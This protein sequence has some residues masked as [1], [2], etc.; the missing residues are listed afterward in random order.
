M[1][2]YLWFLAGCGPLQRCSARSGSLAD[3]S[4]IVPLD[5]LEVQ[6]KLASPWR[7]DLIDPCV[8]GTGVADISSGPWLCKECDVLYSFDYL[9]IIGIRF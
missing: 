4:A 5:L 6:D 1:P 8:A 7:A 2:R 3:F 9:L